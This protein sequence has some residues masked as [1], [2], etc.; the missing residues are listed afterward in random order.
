VLTA[1]KIG[2]ILIVCIAGVV[3]VSTQETSTV[4]D[5][6][7]AAN[8]FS[9]SDA[10]GVFSGAEACSIEDLITR[11]YSQSGSLCV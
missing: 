4:S 11:L 9:G 5:N 6:L 1:V 7:S 8:A 3:Y 10:W 2:S